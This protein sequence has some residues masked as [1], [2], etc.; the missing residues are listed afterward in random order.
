M[1]HQD[2]FLHET[3]MNQIGQNAKCVAA[4]Q[5]LKDLSTASIIRQ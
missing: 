4:V 1:F 2:L 3:Q 5:R